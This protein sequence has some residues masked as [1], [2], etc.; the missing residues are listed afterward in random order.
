MQL[1]IRLFGGM[2]KKAVLPGGIENHRCFNLVVTNKLTLG[3]L[4]DLLAIKSDYPLIGIVNGQ[5]ER[6]HFQLKD[7]DRIGIFPP[8]GGEYRTVTSGSLFAQEKK[9]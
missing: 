3:D 8:F 7:G 5:R 2:D 1:E 9:Q 4:F 6:E